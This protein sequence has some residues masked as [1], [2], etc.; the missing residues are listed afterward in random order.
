MKVIIGFY[1]RLIIFIFLDYNDN[2]NL[3][4]QLAPFLPQDD[5]HELLEQGITSIS[6]V[7]SLFADIDFSEFFPAGC[8]EIL[9]EVMFNI[10]Y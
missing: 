4:A 2:E 5:M 9:P 10:F 3:G 1:L 7:G 6:D 8:G